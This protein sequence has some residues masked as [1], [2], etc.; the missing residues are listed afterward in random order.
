[1]TTYAVDA[2]WLTEAAVCSFDELLEYSGLAAD[3]LVGLVEC[4][5]IVAADD[6]SHHR[7]FHLSAI[8]VART[9]RRLRDDFELDASGLALALDLLRRI[10]ELEAQLREAHARLPR[11]KS[12]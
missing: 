10:D 7:I 2:V 5:M 6:A 11:G 3:E 1:M 9:A 12:L 4:G 8:P